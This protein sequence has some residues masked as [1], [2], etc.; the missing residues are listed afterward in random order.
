MRVNVQGIIGMAR[1]HWLG[2]FGVCFALGMAAQETPPPPASSGQSTT[3]GPPVTLIPRSHEEREQ[4]FQ[5]NHHVI[6][7]VQVTDA[8]GKPVAGLKEDDF[9]LLDE[10]RPQKIASFRAV[11]GGTSS[12]REHVL[13]VLDTLNNSA[14]NFGYERKGIERFLRQNQG[15]LAY[16][17]SIVLLS[18]SG[19]TASQPSTDAGFL[20][21]ELKKVSDH[22]HQ[23]GCGD[24]Q[25]DTGLS[26]VSGVGMPSLPISEAE[27]QSARAADCL[28]QRFRRSVQALD[29]LARDEV[30]IPGRVLVIWAGPG[31]PT[32]KGG[33]FRP[34]T[35]AMQHNYFA[36]LAN[37]ST[38]LREAQVTLD[39]V[40]SPHLIRD[41]ALD[42]EESSAFLNRAPKPD[43]ASASNFALPVLAY[44]TGG[45]VLEDNNDIAHDIAACIRDA[46]SYYAVSFDSVPAAE[47]PE[48][49][50]IRVQVD[51]PGLTVRTS[52]AYYSQP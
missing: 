5:A 29:Q 8:A 26:F 24:N 17:M 9:T 21:E 36:Y 15:R 27:A 22:V 49:H 41:V 25:G 37:L 19:A 12:T 30:E 31:W 51:Q 23:F 46:E 33:E 35:Q 14:W 1:F 4:R 50:S 28:N 38:S 7:N 48:Y 43:E 13:L 20:I 34:D 10:T 6:L 2:A 3:P 52:T 39:A 18:T 16:P 45:Q 47:G 11:H 44:Q 42:R 40:S 32:L